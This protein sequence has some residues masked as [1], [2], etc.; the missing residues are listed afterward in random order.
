M[1][2]CRGSGSGWLLV[3]AVV[4]ITENYRNLPNSTENFRILNYRKLTLTQTLTG[5]MRFLRLGFRVK[6][7]AKQSKDV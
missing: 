3:L 7:K 1:I 5:F 2:C 6:S 4:I